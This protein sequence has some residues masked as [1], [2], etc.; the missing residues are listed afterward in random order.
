[1]VSSFV[2][3][4]FQLLENVIYSMCAVYPS[5]ISVPGVF[6]LFDEQPISV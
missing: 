5:Y 2:Y 3:Q 1:M 6:T 4:L